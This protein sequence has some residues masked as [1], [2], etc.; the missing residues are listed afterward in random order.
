MREGNVPD[1]EDALRTTA[2][3]HTLRMAQSRNSRDEMNR[4][5]NERTAA[6]W[7]RQTTEEDGVALFLVGQRSL[8]K[9][10]AQLAGWKKDG[11]REKKGKGEFSRRT[12]RGKAHI[13]ADTRKASPV[14]QQLGLHLAL[15]RLGF[16]GSDPGCGPTSHLSA[17]AVVGVAHIKY[18]KMG[19]DVG[20][21]PLFLGKRRRI[22][23]RC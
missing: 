2:L 7:K 1:S 10:A 16:A 14:A 23:G 5:M 13:K 3:H 12:T 11:F 9:E 8:R 18:G 19:M 22:G 4:W 6:R 21:G 17:H 20:S 15:R